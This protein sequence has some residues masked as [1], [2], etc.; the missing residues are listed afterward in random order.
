[1]DKLKNKIDLMENLDDL[2]KYQG[3]WKTLWKYKNVIRRGFLTYNSEKEADL[4]AQEWMTE[5]I[6]KHG[7]REMSIVS[8]TDK[9]LIVRT[10][11]SEITYLGAIP[12]KE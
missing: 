9:S 1:M 11:A 7:D 4:S 10:K 2:E 3:K 5:T 6:R 12:V 8:R